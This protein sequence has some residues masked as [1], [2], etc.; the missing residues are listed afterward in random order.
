ML[1]S[2][3]RI[4]AL[5]RR[6]P[7]LRISDLAEAL[8]VGKPTALRHVLKHR[9]LTLERTHSGSRVWLNFDLPD[10]LQESDRVD[11]AVRS[12]PGPRIFELDEI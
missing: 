11:K 12:K 9:R 3:W 1:I 10:H 2:K 5:V 4:E 8:G 6:Y 7:G